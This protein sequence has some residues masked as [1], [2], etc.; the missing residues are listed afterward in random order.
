MYN[1]CWCKDHVIPME[2]TTEY[3][4]GSESTDWVLLGQEGLG[5]GGRRVWVPH[6]LSEHIF[7]TIKQ[8]ETARL[9]RYCHFPSTIELT[10]Q[11]C[12]LQPLKEEAMCILPSELIMCSWKSVVLPFLLLIF[13]SKQI[14]HMLFNLNL[15]HGG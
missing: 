5:V 14:F 10:L 15:N 13:M 11:I 9:N 12:T 1:T 4:S 2:L 3:P 8:G 7:P 6:L